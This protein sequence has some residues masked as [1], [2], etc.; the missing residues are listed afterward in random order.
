MS[1]FIRDT[2]HGVLGPMMYDPNVFTL[3]LEQMLSGEPIDTAIGVLQITVQGARDLKS[4]KL[5][6]SRPDP[7]VSLSINERVELAK[8]KFK[9]NTYVIAFLLTGRAPASAAPCSSRISW[10]LRCSAQH[11][12]GH[13]LQNNGMTAT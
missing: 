3:N 9:H 4:S 12:Y 2:V 13:V 1:A 11:I 5:G 10:F 6:G 7:Y 8:T